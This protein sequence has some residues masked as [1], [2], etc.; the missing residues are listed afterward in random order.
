MSKL[1]QEIHGLVKLFQSVTWEGSKAMGRYKPK[2]YELVA[3]RL[4]LFHEAG[5]SS[6]YFVALFINQLANTSCSQEF[7]GFMYISGK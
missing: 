7:S 5:L 2:Q 4:V 6:S 1:E 3:E